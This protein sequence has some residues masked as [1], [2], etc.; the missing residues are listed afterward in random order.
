MC[1]SDLIELGLAPVP[2]LVGLVV[3]GVMAAPFGA[4]VA[5]RVPARPLMATVGLLVCALANW[6]LVKAFGFV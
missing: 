2:A 5:R 3:G 6:Q 4:I 1:S